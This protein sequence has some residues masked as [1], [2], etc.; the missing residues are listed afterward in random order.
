MGSDTSWGG[1]KERIETGIVYPHHLT[2]VLS[3]G[4]I[5]GMQALPEL[6]EAY[7]YDS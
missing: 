5:N 1:S 2:V 6:S 3:D 4:Y 7:D